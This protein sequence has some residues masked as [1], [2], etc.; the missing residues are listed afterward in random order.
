M[1]LS[2]NEKAPDILP[3]RGSLAFRGVT[4]GVKAHDRAFTLIELLVVIAIIAILAAILMPVL[5]KA[6]KRA[7][8]AQCI[9]NMKQLQECY[10][11][12]LGDNSDQVPI[13]L[14]SGGT[15]TTISENSWIAGN[16]QT[17]I[18]TTNI[19]QGKLYDYN[20]QVAIYAC[21]ANTKTIAVTSFGSVTHVPQTRTC[22]V[23][24]SLGGGSPPGAP[25]TRSVMFGSYAK[26]LQVRD[27][28]EKIVFVDENENSVGDGCFGLYPYGSVPNLVD[29]WWNM[30]G[31]RHNKGCTFSFVDGH[32]EYWKWH[33]SAVLTYPPSTGNPP[34]VTVTSDWPADN[35]D[36]LPRVSAGGSR[37]FPL[38]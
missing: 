6:K 36:D 26:G 3:G 10:I 1:T 32:A 27:P 9:N 11:L 25:L 21:P 16:A 22:S 37:L 30:A 19:Q 31:S 23:D 13:N 20:K 2:T 33:G 29:T 15:T 4:P 35:S 34:N 17:D 14:T 24:F 7:L 12:Y 38:Q 18:S 5:D 28:S 8:T